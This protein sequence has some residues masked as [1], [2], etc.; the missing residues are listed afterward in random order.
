MKKKAKQKRAD[1]PFAVLSVRVHAG[2]RRETVGP[3]VDGCLKVSVA[4]PP[5]KG[6]AN[7]AVEALLSK[8]LGVSK[9][10]VTLTRGRT[11]RRKTFRIEGMSSASLAERLRST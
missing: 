3:V 1:A 7:Q 8:W 11:Q 10:S 5:E 6:K 9:A 2:A 4:A